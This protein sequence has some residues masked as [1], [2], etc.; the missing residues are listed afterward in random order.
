M[1]YWPPETQLFFRNAYIH[2]VKRGKKRGRSARKSQ[3]GEAAG[4]PHV[5]PEEGAAWE[6]IPSTNQG[7]S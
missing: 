7:S 3:A 4:S 5:I 1:P 2:P 6:S